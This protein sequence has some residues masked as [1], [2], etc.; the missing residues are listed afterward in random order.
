MKTEKDIAMKDIVISWGLPDSLKD[1][2]KELIFKFDDSGIINTNEEGYA[3]RDGDVKFCLFEPATGLALFTMEFFKV[4]PK[5]FNDYKSVIWLELLYVHN[6]SL[7]KV[8]IASYFMKKLIQY[9]IG[10]KMDY[11][12]INAIADAENFA[13]DSFVNVLNQKELEAFYHKFD[14]K[15]MPIV[16]YAPE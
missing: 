1:R 15:E 4:S 16:I 12:K 8:G 6:E 14:S 2:S 5:F 10:E 7:R 3:Y 13:N 9:A 11:I